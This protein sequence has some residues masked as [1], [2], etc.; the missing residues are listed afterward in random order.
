MKKRSLQVFRRPA[1]YLFIILNT[2]AFSLFAQTIQSI[3]RPE[4]GHFYKQQYNGYDQNWGIDQDRNTKFIYVANSKGLLEYDGSNWEEYDLPEKQKIRSLAVDS[5]GRIFTGALGEFGYWAPEKSG[6]LTYHSLKN[7]ISDSKFSEEEVWNIVPTPS[8]MLFQSFAYIYLYSHNEVKKLQSPGSML[9]AREVN[10]QIY[11]P[12]IGI[13]VF[14]LNNEKFELLKGTE[15]L[16]N[17]SVNTILPHKN[18]GIIIGTDKKIYAYQKEVLTEFNITTNIFTNQ[19]HLN[20]GI[21]LSNGKYAFGT[22]L[23][24]L[25]I[26]NDEGDIL[27]HL[28]Q[29]SGLQ[30]NTILSFA[31]GIDGDLWIGLDKGID[32]LKINAPILHFNDYPGTIGTV[33]DAAI[34][35][36]KL[37]LGTNHGV[38]YTFLNGKNADFKI[39][40]ETQGQAW[41]LELI[42][43][44]LLCGH[45]KGTFLIENDIATLISNVTGGWTLRKLK[46][47]P[48]HLIQG[49]YTNLIIYKKDTRGKWCFSHL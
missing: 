45:N 10:N 39:V 44:Q 32:L 43:N 17:E 11:I 49:T 3:C 18:G 40:P 31:K 46:L 13:G 37:Y 4:I 42:D 28:N 22:I 47:H 5:S 48:D 33:Y 26:T 30:N 35:N 7:L 16:A 15:I 38:F 34:F 12:I 27:F 20:R 14:K 36:Q 6:K 41:D 23:N 1:N 24:G 29:N 9:F 21:V 19:N 25:I 2:F 8:G